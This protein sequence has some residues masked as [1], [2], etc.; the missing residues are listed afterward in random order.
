[1]RP[2]LVSGFARHTEAE[3]QIIS[4]S[5]ETA[6]IRMAN[7]KPYGVRVVPMASMGTS[8]SPPQSPEDRERLKPLADRI[9]GVQMW[10]AAHRS[11]LE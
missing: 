6:E 4:E 8:A 3:R 11:A 10:H 7:L 2:Y 5:R 1:M 9:R